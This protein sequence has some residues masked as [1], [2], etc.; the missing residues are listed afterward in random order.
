[1]ETPK[2][3]KNNLKNRVITPDILRDA[4]YSV[5]KRAKNARDQRRKHENKQVASP[6]YIEYSHRENLY[7]K[8]KDIMLSIVKPT[9]IHE[10]YVVKE[11]R[12][13]VD[14]TNIELEPKKYY[15]FYRDIS[16]YSY[17]EDNFVYKR[18]FY[19][20]IEDKFYLYFLYY[21]V[22]EHTFHTPI[23]E[24]S[25][26]PK[27]TFENEKTKGLEIRPIDELNTRGEEIQG[28]LSVQF[29]NKLVDLIKSKEFTFINTE[30]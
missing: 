2:S 8:M 28:L 19:K 12:V 23:S 26:E 10:L 14:E 9:C 24:K 13:K 4:L 25:Y 29:T 11:K 20:L 3:Y 5:N 16:F 17:H 27:T 30:D 18:K 15:D 21:E 1:M 7:Y 22:G 6:A